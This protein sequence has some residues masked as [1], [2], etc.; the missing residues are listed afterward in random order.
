MMTGWIKDANGK[1]YYLYSTGV[2][3]SNTTISGYKI[4]SNGAW[5][6]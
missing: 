1:W 3:A 6:N 2:M 4:G 5:I